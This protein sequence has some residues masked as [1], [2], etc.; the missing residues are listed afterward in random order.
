MGEAPPCGYA[1]A[2]LGYVLA[3]LVGLILIALC[4]GAL[5]GARARPDGRP[6]RQG[7]ESQPSA[8]EPT[9]DWSVTAT[10]PEIDSAR[11]HTP[12]A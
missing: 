2:M 9:P 7:K 5:G 12:P 4:L 11:K 8:D 1:V 6:R 3:T 10:P